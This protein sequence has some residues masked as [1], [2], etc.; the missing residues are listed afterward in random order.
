MSFYE[1][2]YIV[3]PNLENKALKKTMDSIEKELEKTLSTLSNLSFSQ[4]FFI[5][6]VKINFY[7][8]KFK[9]FFTIQSSKE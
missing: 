1:T 9:K 7:L 6:P 3:D 5:P 2:L 8:G 4:V